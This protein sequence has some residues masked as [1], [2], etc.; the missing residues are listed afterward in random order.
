MLKRIAL[1]AALLVSTLGFALTPAA[2]ARDRDD[3]GRNY[4]HEARERREWRERW[5]RTHGYFD[6][7]GYWHPYGY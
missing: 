3:W 1:P 2:S 6:R 5:H 4:C 7:F